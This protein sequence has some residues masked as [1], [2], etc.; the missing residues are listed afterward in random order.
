M[1]ILGKN[2]NKIPITSIN[3]P[4][5]KWEYFV[6]LLDIPIAFKLNVAMAKITKSSN[7]KKKM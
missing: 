2:N 7:K 4:P 3:I 6:T 5:I 1:I